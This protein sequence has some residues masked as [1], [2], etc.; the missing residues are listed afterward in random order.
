MFEV[1]LNGMEVGELEP[2]HGGT[3]NPFSAK[4]FPVNYRTEI[5]L[6]ST[7]PQQVAAL[8]SVRNYRETSQRSKLAIG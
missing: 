1:D 5:P 3:N 2:T 8:D 6:K 7:S 4:P